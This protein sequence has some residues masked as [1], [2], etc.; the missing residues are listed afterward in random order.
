MQRSNCAIGEA[1]GTAP[2]FYGWRVVGAA[3]VLAVF[4]WGIGFC[5]PPVFLSAIREARGWPL[6]L[7]ASAI[8]THFLI[9]AAMAASLPACYR[10]FGI[11]SVTKAASLSLALGIVGWATAGAP[12]QLFIAAALSGAGWAAMSAAAVNAIVSPWFVRNRPVALAM[13]YNGGS[14]GGVVFSPLWVA[15]IGV[16]GFPTA[17]AAVGL[18][19]LITI[20]VLAERVFSRTPQQMGLLPDGQEPGLP[21]TVVTAARA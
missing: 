14:I 8:S 9:G 1:S 16:L 11:P 13:G 18:V 12:W 3:F 20:W 10:R 4:G 15:A 19:M 7:V 21:A 17:A 6:A 5:G 2:R